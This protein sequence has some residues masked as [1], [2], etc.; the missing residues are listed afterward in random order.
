M[1]FT[2]C[3]QHVARS[4]QELYAVL[5][6]SMGCLG[7]PQVAAALRSEVIASR[8]ISSVRQGSA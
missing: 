5:C 2:A 6:M 4:A 7:T 3:R 1:S 8:R